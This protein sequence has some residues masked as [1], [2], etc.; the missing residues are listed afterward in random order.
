MN[1]RYLLK[2]HSLFP[3][4]G[5]SFHIH[6]PKP[7]LLQ[8]KTSSIFILN[9]GS[10]TVSADVT[11]NCNKKISNLGRRGKVEEARKM[12]DEMP[13]RDIVSYA[14]MI[15]TYLKNNDFPRAENLFY[16]MPERSIVAD[17]AMIDGYAKAGRIEDARK[18]FDHMPE[19]NVFSWT[20]LISGY[21]RSGHVEEARLLFERMPE[22]N[23][24]SWTNV[25]VG[26]A[27]N[28]LI[29]QARATFDQMPEKNVVSWTA[30]IKSYIEN[31]Q[32]DEARK[33]FREM[34][35]PNIYTWN[36]LIQGCLDD[37]RVDEAVRLFNSMPHQNEV[38]WTTMVTGL[39]K[40]GS[41]EHAR[42]YFNQ[43]PK[44]DI[45]AWNAMI[46]TYA[47]IGLIAE[48]SKLFN[49]MQEKNTVTWNAM[50]DG[51]TRNGLKSEALKHLT[52]MLRCCIRPNGTTLASVLTSCEGILELLQ[53]HGLLLRLGFDCDTSLTNALVTMYSRSGD[54]SSA[55][56]AFDNLRVKDIVSWTAMILAYSNHGY[57]YH[58]LQAFAQILRSGAEPDEIT[59]VGVL[60]AC[61]HAGLVN[62]GQRLFDS[63][64]RTYGLTPR[65]E[66]YSCLVDILGRAG[67]IDK[68]MGVVREMP[69]DERDGVVLGALLSSCLLHGNIGL[70][71]HIG[72]ELIELE[73]THSGGY[74][75][76]A[77]VFARSR[78]WDE[79]AQVKKKMKERKVKKVPGISQ[80]E[81]KGKTHTFFVGDR[82]HPESEEIYILLQ[83]KLLPLM[84]EMGY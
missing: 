42:E 49:L 15:T 60:S 70:A 79:Y 66:H 53:A 48:A 34:P 65:A 19:R 56:L 7:N 72:R 55:R 44:K 81:V 54:V 62:K 50:I 51:Y 33:L 11:Y 36:I 61:S 82:S 35:Q 58:A 74:I 76:L 27:R 69:P 18:V 47:D 31:C 37:N 46:T 57:G 23:V 71:N 39:A 26:Y 32:I 2:L 24:V 67:Q 9:Y 29:D 63:M 3:C 41:T 38:S 21:F 8:S 14:S 30:M 83:E 52:L 1:R 4:F 13:H 20:S 43:M 80:I 84:Q 40:N 73:P 78:K 25:V 12:F 5:H 28:G 59:F 64:V 77:N 6:H 45:T 10:S 22:K 16:A 68:A 75:L 17:S